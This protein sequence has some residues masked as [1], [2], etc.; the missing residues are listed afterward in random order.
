MDISKDINWDGSI[1]SEMFLAPPN[2]KFN[3]DSDL[4]EKCNLYNKQHSANLSPNDFL[5]NRS[6]NLSTGYDVRCAEVEGI[7]L[8]P[9]CYFK[10]NLGFKMFAP[11]GWWLELRPRSST[12]AKLNIHALYG[13]IDCDY[14][15]NLLFAG[16][17]NPDECKIFNDNTP[18]KI[19]FGDRVGQLIPVKLQEM[20]VESVS[21]EEFMKLTSERKSHGTGFGSSGKK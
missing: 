12:F 19:E 14:D 16:Q 6:S 2:F 20:T 17:Y 18:I 13:V 1:K 5:P 9:G 10:I 21:D 7:L 3:L 8:K 4:Q 15:K 11:E